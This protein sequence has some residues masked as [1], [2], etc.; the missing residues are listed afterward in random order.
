M[1]ITSDAQVMAYH[2]QTDAQLDPQAAE[3]REVN[4]HSLTTLST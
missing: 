4:S 3:E 1:H 2:A